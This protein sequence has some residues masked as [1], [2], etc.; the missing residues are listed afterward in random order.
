MILSVFYFIIIVFEFS[1][2]FCVVVTGANSGQS[3]MNSQRYLCIF[4]LFCSFEAALPLEFQN[5]LF[6]R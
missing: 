3:A 4:Q 6:L 5:N 1:C 2:I